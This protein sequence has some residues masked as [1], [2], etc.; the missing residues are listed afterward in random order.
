MDVYGIVTEKIISL[1]EQGVVPWRRPWISTGFP[2]N[3]VSKKPY[4]GVNVFLLSASK[5]VSPFWLTYRQASELGGHVRKGEESTLIVYWKVDDVEEKGADAD[6]EQAEPKSHRR[7]LLRYYRVFNVEQC[8][9][10]QA[11]LDKLPKIETHEHDPIEAA[12]KII[13]GMPNPPEIRYAGSKAFYSSI[14]DR[15]TLPP[16]ELFVSAEE[17]YATALH[18]TVHSTG[19]QKR[20]ARESILEAAAFGSQTYSAEELVAEMGAA[21]LCAEAK[22]SN[23]VL[24][25]QAAYVAGWLKKLRDDRKLLIHAAAQAQ[26][27]ADYVLNR[28]CYE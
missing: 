22:I 23:V 20:L 13:A 24:E 5:Y 17:F 7:F 4:R 26:R 9:L 12:E 18:E 27:A 2:R 6:H 1:L 8:E 14:T 19:S 16:R 11:A 15:I 25:N 28:A 10:P 3:L 21:Y